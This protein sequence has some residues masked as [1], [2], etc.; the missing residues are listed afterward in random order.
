[1]LG[2]GKPLRWNNQEHNGI[3]IGPSM[4]P[5]FFRLQHTKSRAG[6]QFQ[7]SRR[8]W[9]VGVE[10]NL[11]AMQLQLGRCHRFRL[12]R[13][14]VIIPLT[15]PKG[16]S[17][18]SSFGSRKA[19]SLLLGD[20]GRTGLLLVRRQNEALRPPVAVVR[21]HRPPCTRKRRLVSQGAYVSFHSFES[22]PPCW[23][24]TQMFAPSK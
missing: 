23:L 11:N 17:L 13:L 4:A 20:L 21:H 1:M 15:T 22:V 19:T 12:T 3:L 24:L 9:R 14:S 2:S 16:W 18:S 7:I 5:R 10:T 6:F 8:G